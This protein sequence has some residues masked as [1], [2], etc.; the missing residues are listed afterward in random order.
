MDNA[1]SPKL[2]KYFSFETALQTSYI[3]MTVQITKQLR[4]N[5]YNLNNTVKSPQSSLPVSYGLG[6]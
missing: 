5:M 3:V 6:C 2:T 4:T 1:V